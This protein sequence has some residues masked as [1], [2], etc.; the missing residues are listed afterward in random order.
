MQQSLIPGMA[1]MGGYFIH[2]WNDIWV[3]IETIRYWRFQ[4]SVTSIRDK[5][6]CPKRDVMCDVGSKIEEESAQT[7]SSSGDYTLSLRCQTGS[8]RVWYFNLTLVMPQSLA[9][10]MKVYYV[11]PYIGSI[12]LS[13]ILHGSINSLS[14]VSEN[15]LNWTFGHCWYYD[16]KKVICLDVKLAKSRLLVVSYIDLESPGDM[17]DYTWA[18]V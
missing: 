6:S 1:A 13:F 8:S 2:L 3:V 15:N 12:N 7:L 11:S 17:C 18:R 5:M 10:G 9:S 14:W 16:W 4:D